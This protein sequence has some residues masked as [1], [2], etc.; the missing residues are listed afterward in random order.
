MQDVA[1]VGGASSD[2]AV[3]DPY[4]RYIGN[5]VERAGLQ[6]AELD[7]QV[8]GGFMGFSSK[9]WQKNW[10]GTPDLQERLAREISLDGAFAGKP[11]LRKGATDRS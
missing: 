11:A 9:A 4:A 7:V 6:L 5:G 10:F 2:V 1:A 8:G 3:A